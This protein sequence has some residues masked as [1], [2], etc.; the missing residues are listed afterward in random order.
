MRMIESKKAAVESAICNA[1]WDEQFIPMYTVVYF[2]H[3]F[4]FF[5]FQ[6]SV[7]D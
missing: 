6:D 4:N 3:I 1:S 7:R 2:Q 5:L